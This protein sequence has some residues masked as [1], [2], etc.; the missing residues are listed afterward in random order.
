MGRDQEIELFIMN[1]KY[2]DYIYVHERK[3]F[4]PT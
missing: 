4:L 3:G 2:V 1:M